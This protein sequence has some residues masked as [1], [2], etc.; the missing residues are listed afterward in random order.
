M[1]TEEQRE[2]I[3][4]TRSPAGTWR[5]QDAA[6]GSLAPE[7]VLFPLCDSPYP[8]PTEYFCLS[9]SGDRMS[10]LAVANSVPGECKLRLL[11][12]GCLEQRPEK[13]P[14]SA[15]GGWLLMSAIQ[16]KEGAAGL[17]PVC[18]VWTIPLKCVDP[19]LSDQPHRSLVSLSP[20]INPRSPSSLWHPYCCLCFSVLPQMHSP[21]TARCP[22]PTCGHPDF[23]NLSFLG[24]SLRC[25]VW[26]SVDVHRPPPDRPLTV[27]AG[28]EVHSRLRLPQSLAPSR[29]QSGYS[30]NVDDINKRKIEWMFFRRFT[31]VHLATSLWTDLV[32]SNTFGFPT[33]PLWWTIIIS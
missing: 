19:G 3:S 24:V 11:S 5:N 20:N 10:I 30:A 32:S 33:T 1:E 2:Q 14:G 29:V 7:L 16:N 28:G 13:D 4:S 25:A 17:P 9:S 6:L 26:V 18:C 8:E 31:F 27:G 22:T 12:C 23:T 15:G 21:P